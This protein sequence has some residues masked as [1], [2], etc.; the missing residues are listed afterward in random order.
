MIVNAGLFADDD[1]LI[2]VTDNFA[3]PLL[4]P[5]PPDSLAKTADN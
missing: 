2:G 1:F 3:A 5:T 4:S